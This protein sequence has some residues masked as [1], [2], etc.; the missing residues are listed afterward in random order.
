MR[1]LARF[2]KHDPSLSHL[3]VQRTFQRALRRGGLPV[4]Y[5]EGY[6]PHPVLSFA[7]ALS[8]GITSEAEWLDCRMDGAFDAQTAMDALN[9]ALPPGLR[10]LEA[11]A[12]DVFPALTP[13]TAWAEYRVKFPDG[14]PS[15]L[16]DGVSPLWA[17]KRGKA[18]IKRVDLR[19]LV[20][21]FALDSD[22]ALRLRC[23]HTPA[24]CLN[25]KLLLKALGWTGEC[26]IHRT[27]LLNKAGEPLSNP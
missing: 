1:L 25:P 24:Q 14:A 27:K 16:W 18:G 26:A 10:V 2:E 11:H 4:L 22:A 13:H 21:E 8:V 23:V 15:V 17:E 6:N 7:S 9:G 12:V 19:P 5:S 3:D 20:T